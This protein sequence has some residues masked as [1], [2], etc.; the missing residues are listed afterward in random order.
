MKATTPDLDELVRRHGGYD[1]ITAEAWDEFDC[2]TALYQKRRRVEMFAT[3]AGNARAVVRPVSPVASMTLKQIKTELKE[4][5]GRPVASAEDRRRRQMLWHR[6]DALT[7][8]QTTQR[9]AV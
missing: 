3:A 4:I 5:S 7:D 8:Q 9:K 6:L 2:A 1:K